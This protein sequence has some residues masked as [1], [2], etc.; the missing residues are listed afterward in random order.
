MEPV[1]CS[2]R[3]AANALGLGLTKT[4]ELITDQQLETVR[5]GSRRLVKVS[6]IKRL[7]DGAAMRDAA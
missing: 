3:D 6:S 5:I 2:V 4:Y 7:A 1:L